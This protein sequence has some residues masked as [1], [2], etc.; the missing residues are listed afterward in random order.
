MDCDGTHGQIVP[1]SELH[2]LILCTPAEAPLPAWSPCV[3]HIDFYILI[4]NGI[5]QD[6]ADGSWKVIPEESETRRILIWELVT[7]DARLVSR[8]LL[9]LIYTA[10]DYV[11]I[12]AITQSTSCI[13]HQSSRMQAT[14]LFSRTPM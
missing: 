8:H 6:C 5:L 9:S 11:R 4:L 7:L 2:F 12:G 3:L 14:R 10:V 13:Q 1:S